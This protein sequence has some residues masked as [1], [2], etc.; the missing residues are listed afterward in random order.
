MVIW[1][2]WGI[3]VPIV[4]CIAFFVAAF[5]V[6]IGQLPAATAST[7][8]A[9][10]EILAGGLIGYIALRIESQPGETYVEK[11]TGRE[12]SVGN[13]AGSLFF[14]P[15]RYWAYIVPALGLVLLVYPFL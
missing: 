6:R 8:Y 13:D 7:I 5:L 11:K 10:A 12:F 2:G 3:V 4:G 15:T 9:V 1:S 14:V